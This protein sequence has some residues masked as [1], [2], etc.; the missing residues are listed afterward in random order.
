MRTVSEDMVIC[1]SPIVKVHLCEAVKVCNDAFNSV[2]YR[3]LLGC[4]IVRDYQKFRWR[5]LL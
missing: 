4:L 1:L 5:M 2:L 3:I